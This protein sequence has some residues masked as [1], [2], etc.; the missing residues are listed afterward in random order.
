[1]GAESE[2][3]RPPKNNS[4]EALAHP[5]TTRLFENRANVYWCNTIINNWIIR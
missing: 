5:R 2:L 4:F 3:R 1:M